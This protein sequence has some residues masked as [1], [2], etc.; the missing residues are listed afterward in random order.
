MTR[1]LRRLTILCFLCA[2]GAATQAHAGQIVYPSGTGIWVMNDDGS[3]KR[4]LV[5]ATQLPSMEYL[6]DPSVQPNGTEVAFDGR[7][8]QAYYEQNHWGPAP[9]MCGG[10]C[11]GIYE[12]V[13]GV[14]TRV[15]NAPFDCGAQPCE[16]QEVNPRVARDG[17]VAYVFQTY[18][19]EI[20]PSGWMPVDGQSD[21]LA[22]DSAGAHQTRWP[23]ACDGT[24]SSG[25]EITNA[26]VLAVNPLVPTQ[27]AYANCPETANDGSCV[28]DW[29]SAYDVID[30]GPSQTTASDD[31]TYH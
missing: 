19:S 15:T 13:N 8:N 21:L 26:D 10:N 27:I 12:L 9:G 16:S 31:I 1:T 5:D 18:V 28:L 30:S 6:G 23:T 17:S 14:A 20:G 4:Q 25:K 2:L 7:W 24:A 3:A 29:T 22:R 11:E